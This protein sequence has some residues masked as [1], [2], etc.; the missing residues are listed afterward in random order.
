VIDNAWGGYISGKA[1]L[2]D[3]FVLGNAEYLRGWNKYEIDPLGGNRALYNS[4]EYHYGPL[5]AFYDAGAI[6]DE[7]QPIVVRHSV[8]LGL[9]ESVFS[10]AVAIPMR[11]GHIEP[12]FM[13]GILP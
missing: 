13:M 3:R 4:V 10:L 9:R 5:L 2:S 8:G 6:W 1:P 11:S 7:S 12:I